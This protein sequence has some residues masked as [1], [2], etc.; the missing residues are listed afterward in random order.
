MH[1]S[2]IT[3]ALS[4]RPKKSADLRMERSKVI[5][6]EYNIARDQP[7]SRASPLGI[8]ALLSGDVSNRRISS[9]DCTAIQ[10]S[11]KFRSPMNSLFYEIP[12]DSARSCI[13]HFGQNASCGEICFSVS[14]ITDLT[15]EFIAAIHSSS[16]ENSVFSE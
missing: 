6:P 14:D 5:N 1:L 16:V 2:G 11:F 15:N 4:Q 13:R 3:S 7:T 12:T 8:N 10:R 9:M